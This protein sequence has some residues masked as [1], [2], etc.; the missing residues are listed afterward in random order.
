MFAP[1]GTL[2]HQSHHHTKSIYLQSTYSIIQ[3]GGDCQM[4]YQG[5]TDS[6]D[7]V[8][9][10]SLWKE[11]RRA[12]IITEMDHFLYEIFRAF[13]LDGFFHAL[14]CCAMVVCIH[15]FQCFNL[16]TRITCTSQ[17]AVS[18]SFQLDCKV[19]NF[20]SGGMSCTSV[21]LMLPSTMM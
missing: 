12:G 6:Q 1:T 11:C 20:S 8:P 21:Q 5:Y 9:G 15:C 3:R 7:I 4:Q 2:L 17:T 10:I 18:I 16:W 13:S 14:Q 19:L